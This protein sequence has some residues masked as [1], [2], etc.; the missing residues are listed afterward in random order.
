MNLSNTGGGGRGSDSGSIV[1]S[2]ILHGKKEFW[3]KGGNYHYHHGMAPGDNTLDALVSRVLLRGIID[4]ATEDNAAAAASS[5]GVITPS[6]GFNAERFVRDYIAFMTTPGTHNDTYAGTCHRMFFKN[7]TEGR[8]PRDCPDNDGHNVDAIDALMTVPII[9]AL[10]ASNSGLHDEAVRNQMVV[11][12]IRCTRNSTVVMRY[13]QLYASMLHS[14]LQGSCT[15]AEA[16]Q[17]AGLRIGKDF[18]AI[19]RTRPGAADPMCACYIDSA[20]DALLYFA[21]KYGDSD[22]DGT[23]LLLRS[24][25][26][27][28]ENVAR[29]SLLGALVGARYGLDGLPAHLRDG[30]VQSEGIIRDAKILS[31]IFPH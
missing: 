15:I 22:S 30:L 16:A 6:R 25:N 29:G 14:V 20:F 7:L 13:A 21:V 3:K 5:A 28:G 18:A 23:T 1:G 11:D 8:S 24:T 9:V 19:V 31:E 27:G 26:A 4:Q 2:V 17:A 12:C 10:C